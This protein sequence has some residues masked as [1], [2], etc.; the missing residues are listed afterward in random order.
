MDDYTTG[1]PAEAP[2]SLRYDQSGS[3]EGSRL[4]R[5]LSPYWLTEFKKET[6]RLNSVAIEGK[7]IS[8]RCSVAAAY[9]SPYYNT[10]RFSA[11]NAMALVAQVAIV[12]AHVLSGKEEKTGESLLT[13]YGITLTRIIKQVEDVSIQ[14]QLYA[15]SVVEA[16]GR[17][18][19]P[20]SF[21]SW[22]F[23]IC[24]DAWWGR[25]QASFPF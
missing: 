15:H 6:P 24:D 1:E 23:S 20:R 5:F 11:A 12:H 21:F 18:K 25:V 9:R 19:V 3:Y 2:S 14:M 8:A 22:R 4:D 10:E 16:T 13:D 7:K 17:R